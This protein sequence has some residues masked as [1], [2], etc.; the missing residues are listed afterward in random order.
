M[1]I[2]PGGRGID[3]RRKVKILGEAI[4]YETISSFIISSPAI[5]RFSSLTSETNSIGYL[6]IDSSLTVC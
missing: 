6:I 2:I 4:N 1:A 3:G 5:K